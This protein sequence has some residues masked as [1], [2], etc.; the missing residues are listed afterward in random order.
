MENELNE[1]FQSPEGQRLID[2]TMFFNQEKIEKQ[3][4]ASKEHLTGM[5]LMLRSRGYKAVFE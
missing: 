2:A 5:V 4:R 3:T 1:Y